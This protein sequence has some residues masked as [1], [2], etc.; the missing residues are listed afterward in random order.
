M[1]IKNFAPLK[2]TFMN[3]YLGAMAY[4]PTLPHMKSLDI[5]MSAYKD[6][7]L[8]KP[9]VSVNINQLITSLKKGYALTSGGKF[10]DALPIMQ[11]ILH[12]IP[13]LS[14]RSESEENEAKELVGICV[15]YIGCIRLELAK[16]AALKAGEHGKALELGYYMTLCNTQPPHQGLA[17]QSA[18]SL[19]YKMKNLI[20]C[21]T[22]CKRFLELAAKHPTLIAKDK[23]DRH[24][25]LL[26]YC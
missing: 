1:G 10:N 17:L 3:I 18:I 2:P 13:L 24:K 25:K 15:E 6:A 9:H 14:V 8:T 12:S 19:T 5:T 21:T 7:G 23:V 4:L 26:A 20:N 11:G 22:L 16:Q